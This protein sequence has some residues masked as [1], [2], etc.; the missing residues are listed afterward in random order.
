M[1]SKKS[2]YVYHPPVGSNYPGKE[3]ANPYIFYPP[4]DLR[5][6]IP[7]ETNEDKLVKM[8]SAL[9]QWERIYRYPGYPYRLAS[10]LR[11]IAA[12][13]LKTA[14]REPPAINIPYYQDQQVPEGF[15]TVLRRLRNIHD[16]DDYSQFDYTR[17]GE[18]PRVDI[19][20]SKGN[21]L[22]PS[23]PPIGDSVKTKGEG[24]N[25]DITYPFP[26]TGGNLS[27]Y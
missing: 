5:R 1:L 25:P 2:D 26:P 17:Q 14:E 4:E 3:E 23:E 21:Y 11:C 7:S 16:D 10:R 27:Q 15:G 24:P 19:D 8:K 9:R 13:L 6:M 22:A 12:R 20:T 18:R